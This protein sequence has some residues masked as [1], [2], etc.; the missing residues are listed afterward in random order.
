LTILRSNYGQAGSWSEGDINGDGIVDAYDIRI[1]RK[2]WGQEGYRYPDIQPDVPTGALSG[3]VNVGITGDISTLASICLFLDG[4]LV[5]EFSDSTGSNLVT[6]ETYKY[7]N[8]DH[9][10][11]IIGATSLGGILLSQEEV[12]TFSNPLYYVSAGSCYTKTGGY[13]IAGI[14]DAE[15]SV[16]VKIT[17]IFDAEVCSYPLTNVPL[18]FPMSSCEYQVYTVNAIETATSSTLFGQNIYEDNNGYGYN[19][20]MVV[21]ITLSPDSKEM[22]EGCRPRLKAVVQATLTKFN[23]NFRVVYRPDW[24]D[25]K[26][27]LKRPL[28][29]YWYNIAHGSMGVGGTYGGIVLRTNFDIRTRTTQR[30][31]S[32]E[33]GMRVFSYNQADLP[34]LPLTPKPEY[35]YPLP[36]ENDVHTLASLGFAKDTR[37]KIVFMDCCECGAN[38]FCDQSGNMFNDM[39]LAMGMYSVDL[40]PMQAYFGWVNYAKASADENYPDN[41]YL[42]RLWSCPPGEGLGGPNSLK[43]AVLYANQYRLMTAIPGHLEIYGN[44]YQMYQYYGLEKIS[45]DR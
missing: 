39:A 9:K 30:Y 29:H 26:Y 43:S 36:N 42:T 24:E 15:T 25:L 45:Y 14:H 34:L 19:D 38:I 23:L 1:L 37:F 6:L 44:A 11:K 27:F 18:N 7:G 41:M 13:N 40:E 4:K 32:Y 31:G 22:E 8:G 12:V 3:D 35:C 33:L 16:A 20:D 2:Q 5:G 21:L 17:D 28:L 10:I